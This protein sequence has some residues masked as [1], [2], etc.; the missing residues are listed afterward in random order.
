MRAR[1]QLAPKRARPRG[2]LAAAA[3]DWD[4]AA[5]A[6]GLHNR[7]WPHLIGRPASRARQK[8]FECHSAANSC[9]AHLGP[10]SGAP[11]APGRRKCQ[12][13]AER[14]MSCPRHRR[15][16]IWSLGPMK[17]IVGPESLFDG[18][19]RAAESRGGREIVSGARLAQAR[20]CRWPL[21]GHQVSGERRAAASGGRP[22]NARHEMGSRDR[23]PETPLATPPGRPF[24][25]P[26][27]AAPRDPTLF[28]RAPGAPAD[29]ELKSR[30]TPAGPPPK[31]PSSVQP[32]DWPRAVCFS[33]Q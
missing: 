23:V 29:S 32:G 3:A 33:A 7:R 5:G 17:W 30:R 14:Q 9:P 24:A 12:R 27:E 4:E 20:H 6:P 1:A 15:E 28:I 16:R 13:G 19:E 21:V 8:L 18:F 25:C 2:P 11:P 31:R 22:A 10:S 26:L